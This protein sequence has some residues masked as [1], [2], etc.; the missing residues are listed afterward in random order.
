[1]ANKRSKIV[2]S[3]KTN[4][5]NSKKEDSKLVVGT[6]VKQDFTKSLPRPVEMVTVV[7]GAKKLVNATD[8]PLSAVGSDYSVAPGEVVNQTLVPG[9]LIRFWKHINAVKERNA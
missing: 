6:P 5:S 3:N 1:M 2:G 4:K 9:H 7:K 8:R